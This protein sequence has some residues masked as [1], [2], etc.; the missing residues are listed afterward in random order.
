MPDL[1]FI[2]I[3]CGYDEPRRAGFSLAHTHLCSSDSSEITITV[4]QTAVFLTL[5][6]PKVTRRGAGQGLHPTGGKSE[7]LRLAITEGYRREV[8]RAAWQDA[9]E[10]P[11]EGMVADIAV[12][13]VAVA[14]LKYREGCVRQFEWRVKRIGADVGG[15]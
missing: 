14:E 1:C 11:L 8:E 5:D 10:A 12:E 6:R 7:P 9:E 2:F 4:H 13:I 15:G 3:P